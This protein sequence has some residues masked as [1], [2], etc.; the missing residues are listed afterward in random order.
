M[1]NLHVS[2]VFYFR[3][4]QSFHEMQSDRENQQP[5]AGMV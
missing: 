1:E 5:Y 3:S 2:R 4:M